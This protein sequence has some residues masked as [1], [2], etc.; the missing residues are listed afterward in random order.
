MCSFTANKHPGCGHAAHGTALAHSRLEP[1][2]KAKKNGTRCQT[3][4]WKPVDVARGYCDQCIV[5]G[6]LLAQSRGLDPGTYCQRMN[7]SYRDLDEANPEAFLS[8]RQL[9]KNQSFKE[10]QE[11]AECTIARYAETMP[12]S[13]RGFHRR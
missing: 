8:L 7:S 6:E 3:A 13:S 11:A 9:P 10:S 12:A 1:C 2:R 4:S 5:R